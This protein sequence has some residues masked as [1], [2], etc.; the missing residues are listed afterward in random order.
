MSNLESLSEKAKR[1]AGLIYDTNDPE[2][3]NELNNCKNLCFAINQINPKFLEER[4]LALKRL[5]GS[6]GKKL[7]IQPQ[8]WC[9]FGYNI[10]VGENFYANHNCVILDCAEVRFGDN[11]LL[12]PDCKFYTPEH[13]L[14]VEARNKGLEYAKKI[15][16]GD[17]V[18]FGGSVTVLGG[19]SI[20]S[21]SVIGAGS[22]VTHDIPAG[23][24][25]FGHPCKIIRKL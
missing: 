3:V 20:G 6:T 1:A 9:D 18:W 14:E 16:V 2:L 8:F 4:C 10:H 13:P 25:A 12:G 19:V 24:L 17:N 23:V 7:V 11:V 21:N 22:L 5:L 15:T